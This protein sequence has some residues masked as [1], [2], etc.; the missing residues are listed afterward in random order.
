MAVAFTLRSSKKI[1][2]AFVLF[3]DILLLF[4]V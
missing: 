3:A 1:A 2:M 4:E